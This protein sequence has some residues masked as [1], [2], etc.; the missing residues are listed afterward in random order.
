MN[1]LEVLCG[2]LAGI[3]VSNRMSQ[4]NLDPAAYTAWRVKSLTRLNKVAFSVFAVGLFWIGMAFLLTGIRG[5]GVW[6]L[7]LAGLSLLYGWLWAPKFVVHREMRR[8]AR[9]QHQAQR[10]AERLAR[11]QLRPDDPDYWR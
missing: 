7:V 11:G 1:P 6:M 2:A 10:E 4:R 5:A 3:F 8:V 9:A